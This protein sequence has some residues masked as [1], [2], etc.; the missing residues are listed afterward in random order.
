MSFFEE[1]RIFENW[2]LILSLIPGAG[3]ITVLSL[4][5]NVQASHYAVLPLFLQG[6]I[7]VVVGAILFAPKWAKLPIHTENEFIL[8]RY[9]D[10]FVKPLYY[11]RAYYLGLIII[12]LLIHISVSAVF[13]A[14]LFPTPLRDTALFSC[15]LIACIVTFFNNLKNRIILDA[16]TGGVNLLFMLIYV[17]AA[18]LYPSENASSLKIESLTHFDLLLTLCCFWWMNNVIDM[19]DMRAQKLLVLKSQKWSTAVIL[20]PVLIIFLFEAFLVWGPSSSFVQPWM[21][22]FLIVLNLI[23]IIS[24]LQ[25]WSGGLT[26]QATSILFPKSHHVL[27]KRP[28]IFLLIVLFVSFFWSCYLRNTADALLA[29]FG[30]TAG[31]GPVYILRWYYWRINALTQL[32]AMIGPIFI[33]AIIPLFKNTT[34]YHEL[35]LILPFDELYDTLLIASLVNITLW[36]PTLF[37]FSKN[38]MNVLSII[39]KLK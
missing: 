6:I 15:W 36:L 25:H 27:K 33:S 21:I 29:F 16:L 17:L 28:Y 8:H 31:V 11:F 18:F 35:I 14:S 20:I 34:L 22:Q 23:Q 10:P 38:R 32:V 7:G 12:P 37:L 39:R 3:I 26:S 13:N 19:P 2:K 5:T 4:K 24:S 9:L 1:E 30:L